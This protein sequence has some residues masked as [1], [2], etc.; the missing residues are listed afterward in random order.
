MIR[1]SLRSWGTMKRDRGESGKPGSIWN[2][3]LAAVLL[4]AAIVGLA[5]A[6]YLFHL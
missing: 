1:N 2:M 6:M 5:F 3:T 4:L